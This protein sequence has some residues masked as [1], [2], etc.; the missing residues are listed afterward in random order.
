MSRAASPISERLVALGWVGPSRPEDELEEGRA[1]VLRAS[2]IEDVAA[3]RLEAA[4][5]KAHA[6]TR[7]R[8]ELKD[9]AHHEE[10]RVLVGLGRESESIGA[11]RLACRASPAPRR[12]F[13]HFCLGMALHFQGDADGAIAV[14]ERG[15]RW[16][17]GDR[18]LVRGALAWARLASGRAQPRLTA[19]VEA[20]AAS[21]SREGY[22]QLVL[23]MIA[24]HTGDTRRAT[25]HLRAFLRRNARLEPTKELSLRSELR[26]ARRALASIESL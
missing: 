1:L 2:L 12:S 13:H 25:A 8:G 26:A 4:L 17:H 18:A 3:G 19:I 23:G 20:L 9:I 5:E 16:A 7:L 22:G 21:P 15:R 14:L 6:M 11:L 24:F 10:A